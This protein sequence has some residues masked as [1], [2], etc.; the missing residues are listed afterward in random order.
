MKKV[1]LDTNFLL[2]PVQFKLDI[3]TVIPELLND[4]VEFYIVDKT[5]EELRMLSRN[6]GRD[7]MAAKVALKLLGKFGVKKLKSK[8][9]KADDAIVDA[10]KNGYIVA[11]ND[12]ELR[13][14]LER[15]GITTI[16]LRGKKR[17]AV[18]KEF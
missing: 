3:F 11:T 10:A 8:G 9:K 7:G 1:L 13:R 5:L 2:L 16:F 14:R 4:R 18:S 6:K 15:I 17:L 12:V